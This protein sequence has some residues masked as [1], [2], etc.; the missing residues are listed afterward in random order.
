[1]DMD[2]FWKAFRTVVFNTTIGNAVAMTVI[3]PLGMWRGCS[4][5]KELPTF[6]W[7]LFELLVFVL[8]EE[9]GFYYTHR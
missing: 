4:F 9:V 3:Y 5:G 6:H 2:K 1:M 8:C 7:V